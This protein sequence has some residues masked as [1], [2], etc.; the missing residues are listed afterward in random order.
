MFCSFVECDVIV[1]NENGIKSIEEGV[2][3][4]WTYVVPGLRKHPGEWIHGRP[5]KPDQTVYLERLEGEELAVAERVLKE[6]DE[7]DD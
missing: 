2:R 7:D 1:L 4:S 3:I 5:V 6:L